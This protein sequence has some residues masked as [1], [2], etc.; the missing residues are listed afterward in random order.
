MK[1]KGGSFGGGVRGRGRGDRPLC[2]G[3]KHARLQVLAK[4]L[5]MKLKAGSTISD[6]IRR[7]R[8]SAP[9]PKEERLKTEGMPNV[10]W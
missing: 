3:H 5:I 7:F 10:F 1:A 9:R 4:V 6:C 2:F 8:T